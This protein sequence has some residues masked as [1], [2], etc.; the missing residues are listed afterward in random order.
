MIE[1]KINGLTQAASALER[2]MSPMQK[3]IMMQA[4]G[5]TVKKQTETRIRTEKTDPTGKPWKQNAP[6]TIAMKGHGN[7]LIDKGKLL[8]SFT[9]AATQNA[10]ETGTPVT[11]ALQNQEGTIGF[12]KYK[13]RTMGPIPARPFMGISDKNA[14][15]LEAVMTEFIGRQFIGS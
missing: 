2:F 9:F 8:G 15:E 14:S 7:I 10:V 13:G 11:Y 6:F 12:R 5:K 3:M 4:L 1:V